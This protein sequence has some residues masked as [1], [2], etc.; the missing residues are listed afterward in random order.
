MKKNK[1][2]KNYY[3]YSNILKYG[4]KTNVVF[5]ERRN[6]K[7]FGALRLIIEE[8]KKGFNFVYIRRK[9]SYSVRSKIKNLFEEHNDFCIEELGSII[10]YN[11]LEKTYYINTD[12][13]KKLVGYVATIEQAMEY[14][15]SYF[16]NVSIIYFDEFIDYSYFEDE[17]KRYVNLIKTI[18]SNHKNITIILNANSV[19]RYCPYFELF[20]IDTN[21]L[22]KGSIATIK[23]KNG[24]TI[25]VEYTKERVTENG[26][27]KHDL[28]IG[29]DNNSSINMIIRGEW[30][31]NDVE[32]KN[33]DGYGWN[34]K[35][36]FLVPVY[37]TSLGNCY[38]LSLYTNTIPIAFVRKVNT[39]NGIVNE[40]I[41]LNLSQDN[42]I[43]L[44]YKT[45]S[46]V[47]IIK[48]INSEFIT[49]NIKKR[50][51]IFKNCIISGRIIFDTL[52]TGTEFLIAYKKLGG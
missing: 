35:N 32:I 43:L 22:K 5:G 39:Q 52:I 45:G 7:T 23:H 20:G 18:T 13:G 11:P 9:S 25:A 33:I 6:G 4:C 8:I 26:E 34:V 38:E 44:S 51:E 17:K 21:K 48:N 36:R 50:L 49:E 29:F 47:P 42:S 30:E 41:K 19:T 2:S 46:Y 3:S 1:K 24:A 31:T 27:Q 28:Y 15:G 37:I 40:K 10:F 14:K 12:N 16:S